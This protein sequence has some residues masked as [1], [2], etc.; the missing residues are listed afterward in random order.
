MAADASDFPDSM[1]LTPRAEGTARKRNR[2]P[3]WELQRRVRRLRLS[4]VVEENTA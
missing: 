1:E 3:S 4:D 2:V